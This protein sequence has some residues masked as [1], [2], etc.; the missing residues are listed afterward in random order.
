MK[1]KIIFIFILF[2]SHCVQFKIENLIPKLVLKLEIGKLVNQ[3]ESEYLNNAYINLPIRI[4]VS[5]SKVF[6]TDYNKSY[7][8]VFNLNANLEFIIGDNID[9]R[10]DTKFILQKF[11]KLGIITINEDEDLFVQNRLSSAPEKPSKI[12][13]EF[14]P[15]KTSGNFDIRETES[16]PSYILNINNKGKLVH[17]IGKNGKNS[18]PF[19]YIEY[20]Q[21]YSGERLY[22]YHR[23]AEQMILSYYEK[24]E[25]QGSLEE[26]KLEIFK[27]KEFEAY[28]LKLDTI[29]P[30]PKNNSALV[31]ISFIGKKDGRFKFRRI[32]K[33]LISKN[34][35]ESFLKEIQYPS[36]VLFAV[37]PNEEFYLLEMESKGDSIKFQVH[38]KEGN[39]I[40]NRRIEF[41]DTR[42]NWRETYIDEKFNIYS[43]KINSNNLEI[44]KWD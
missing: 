39:H 14:L 19:R 17:I 38:D 9:K 27:D 8:K 31:S 24:G 37:N 33:Y 20:M 40:K 29:L 6:I 1:K 2:L 21:A 26:E 10:N 13:Y 44:Y 5:S 23:Y 43:I 42:L 3:V 12:N 4:P 28:N 36:E 18:E 35:F 41:T 34:T 30:N 22:V 25:I 16:I 11:N 15:L 32:Y 7:I